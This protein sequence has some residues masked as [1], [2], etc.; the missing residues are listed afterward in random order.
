MAEATTTTTTTPSQQVQE[1]YKYITDAGKALVEKPYEPYT[2]ELIPELNEGQKQAIAN[3]QASA[4]Q[5]AAGYQA[6]QANAAAALQNINESAG[7]TNAYINQAAEQTNQALQR[8]VANADLAQ[9]GYTQGYGAADRAAQMITQGA[10]VAQPYFTTAKGTADKALTGY[11][12]ASDYATAG[13][14]PLTQATYY[15]QPAYQKAL[16]DTAAV[17]AGFSPEQYQA[18]VQGYLSPYIANVVDATA[19]Q[20]QNV[21]EQQQQKLLGS[22][23]GAGSFGSDRANFGLAALQNQQNLAMGQ[24]LGALL[25]SGYSDAAKNY[26]AALNSQGALAK[27]YGQLGGEAQQALIN[28]GLAQQ[29]AAKN[30]SDIAAQKMAGA[31]SYGALGTAAQNAALQGVGLE[32]ANALLYG[33]L[34][35]GAQDAAMQAAELQGK[36]GSQMGT[37]GSQYQTAATQRAQEAL[38][39]SQLQGSLASDAQASS[40]AGNEAALKASTAEYA[41]KQAQD[42][43]DYQQKMLEQAYPYQNLANFANLAYGLG[44]QGGTSSTTTPVGNDISSILGIGT[45]LMGLLSASDERLKDNMHPIGE[46]YDGQKI[47]RFNYKGDPKTQVGF[48]AQETE[49]HH[50]ESVY[51][52]KEGIRLVDYDQA[53]HHAAKKGHFALGGEASMGGLVP[54]TEERHPYATSGYVS[55][56]GFGQIPYVD[57]PLFETMKARAGLGLVSYIPQV[58]IGRSNLNPERAP[59]Y[60]EKPFSTEGATA[61]VDAA[62]AFNKKYN[63]FAYGGLVPREAHADGEAAAEDDSSTVS[64][65]PSG[66]ANAFSGLGG[67]LPSLFNKGEPL[68]DE[69]KLSIIAAGLGMAASPSPS[70]LQA[71]GQGGLI[72][73]NTYGGMKKAQY[74]YKKALAEQEINARRVATE[75]EANRLRGFEVNL[76]AIENARQSLEYY[77]A[78]AAAIAGRA[79]GEVPPE[80]Q[81]IIDDLT[82]FVLKGAT[83]YGGKAFTPPTSGKPKDVTEPTDLPVKPSSDKDF[84]VPGAGETSTTKPQASIETKEPVTASAQAEAARSGMDLPLDFDPDALLAQ[85]NKIYQTYPDAAK[86]LQDRATTLTTEITKNGGLMVKGQFVPLP[87]YAEQQA[88]REAAKTKAIKEA[89]APFEFVEVTRADGS[90][91]KLPKSE[92]LKMGLISTGLSPAEL[93]RQKEGAKAEFEFVEQMDDE[94]NITLIPKSEA[95]KK[96]PITKSLSGATL[97]TQK[98]M[99]GIN[100]EK[101]KEAGTFLAE[102]PS[103]QQIQNGLINAYTKIDMNRATPLQAD[104]IGTIKSFPALDKTLKSMGIDVDAQGFQGMA[105]VAAKDAIT[106]AFKSLAA[107]T[108]G[109]TTN[110]QLKETL[111]TVAEPEKAPAAKYAVVTQN[112]GRMLQ[113]EA[114]WRDWNK[115][116][117]K[118]NWNTFIDRWT[119]NPEHS[120][121]H[122]TQKAV[123]NTPY[124]AG[125]T[126]KDIDNLEYKRGQAAAPKAATL[127]PRTVVR[128]GKVT[129]GANA[130]K[131]VTEYSDGTREYK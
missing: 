115:V 117:G 32:Q 15:A 54:Y 67:V 58:E 72:G 107:T 113:Q 40:I 128:T 39:A 29:T 13:L 5:S 68:S 63:L 51:K 75:E 76:K 60:E 118:E 90:T 99:A 62:K 43:A 50:P 111:M 36:L 125:M 89:E 46:T 35:T 122:Y 3:I 11:N 94:G 103:V 14:A 95:L 120:I 27:Q 104:I 57:D 65:E 2:G 23:I 17:Y 123:D 83:P 64:A 7:Q 127:A 84:T 71:I 12:Q 45:S 80:L 91:Y 109:R 4:G 22:K 19:A 130:G 59:K 121:E 34:G 88:A 79:G 52:T 37:L 16:A 20:M 74:D 82:D 98:G 126:A 38:K 124:F 110:M 10:N 78:K 6:A 25:Q 55:E 1:N 41:V 48:S 49:K 116:S 85:A 97:E 86:A 93:E 114:M 69:A 24:V 87:G 21:N 112:S 56:R 119:A 131:T 47:Y 31:T 9:K 28:A 33:K 77:R 108:A 61:F 101:N 73:V 8:A 92:A 53:T 129:S 26:M 44:S 70:A 18:S 105:D 100:V 96:G 106:E 42:A 81:K 66:G 30:I 102:L